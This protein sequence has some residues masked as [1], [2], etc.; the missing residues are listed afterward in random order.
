[1]RLPLWSIGDG[2]G[3]LPPTIRVKALPQTIAAVEALEPDIGGV[4]VVEVAQRLRI[5][6][7]SACRR[8]QE[9]Q[10]AGYL[11]NL[12][13]RAGHP[14]KYRVDHD[15]L[16]PLPSPQRVAAGQYTQTTFQNFYPNI[17]SILSH[18]AT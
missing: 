3:S 11:V 17:F 15:A 12:E 2:L 1:M 6:K 8:L 10:Q 18:Y 7:S 4:M 5:N 16:N 13:T 14:A 9:A